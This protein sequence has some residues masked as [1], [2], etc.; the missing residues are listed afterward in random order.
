MAIRRYLFDG[1]S[2]SREI[3]TG[4]FWRD[5]LS[6]LLAT[7]MLV[8][9]QCVLPLS[10]GRETGF[11]DAVMTGL[12]MG[13]IVTTMAWS[14]GDF[15]GAHMNPAVTFA[16][17]ISLKMSILRGIFYI[18][19]QMAGGLAGAGFAYAITPSKYQDR[20]SATT[21]GHLVTPWQGYLTETWITCILVITIMGSTNPVRKVG[22]QMPPLFIGLAVSLCIFAAWNHTGAS[23]NPA[24]SFGPAVVKSVWKDHWV[25]WAGPFSGST[26]AAII[27]FAIFDRVD[28]PKIKDIVLEVND[29]GIR[30]SGNQMTTV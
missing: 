5:L 16:M 27:Y 10:W 17:I 21:L 1:K 3:C 18:I 26:L 12:G 25:Y 29:I 8:S 11:S 19:V 7:F 20:L 14:L 4:S 30:L 6:E 15:G 24:R 28:R 2:M 13:F 23:M 22:A 9:V